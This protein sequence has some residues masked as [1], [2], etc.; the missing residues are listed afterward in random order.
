MDAF[1]DNHDTIAFL[2][3]Q[4]GLS[5]QFRFAGYLDPISLF[6][7]F[8]PVL[9]TSQTYADAL[10]RGLI[11]MREDGRLDGILAQYGLVD[12]QKMN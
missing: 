4:E 1:I 7:A 8:S 2:L 11:A 9:E 3:K 10:D 5:E 6:V 12:W